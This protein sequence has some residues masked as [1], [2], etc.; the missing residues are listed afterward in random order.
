M[1]QQEARFQDQRR[2]HQAMRIVMDGRFR[3]HLPLE[4]INRQLAA[5]QLE[6]VETLPAGLETM[7]AEPIDEHHL[8]YRLPDIHYHYMV[9]PPG[10]P[11][12]IFK[13]IRETST[14]LN[15]L[16]IFGVN[17]ILALFSLFLFAKLRP[18]QALKKEIRKFAEGSMEVPP[19]VSGKD[20]I[21]EVANEFRQ[22]VQK[23]RSLQES[24]SLFL[25]NIMHE[26]KTPIAK[27]TITTDLLPPSKQQDRLRKTFSRLDYLLG[28]LTRLEQFTSGNL[29]LKR[30]DFHLLDILDQS[31]DILILEPHQV[32]CSGPNLLLWVDFEL[33]AIALKN[34]L[35]NALRHGD[36]SVAM[37]TYADR[38]VIE[39]PGPPLPFPLEHYFQPFN[40]TTENSRQ[41][42][43][44]GLYITKSI[45]DAH[46]YGLTYDH[47]SGKN[48]FTI[49]IH[50]T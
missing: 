21:A 41:G 15:R 16:I 6:L 27:G 10:R 47:R 26:L 39:N 38:I 29:P 11:P 28:E 37:T 17:G 50:V 3:Y 8:V 45:L 35:D 42:L 25:R 1:Q 4:S 9:P 19:E 44:L 2:I 13:D 14:L 33:F 43:G 32:P 48:R 34:L 23:I 46:G 7:K 24:R 5:L 12:I 20:E 31:R 30:H 36:G 22:A 18:L 49:H 40:R